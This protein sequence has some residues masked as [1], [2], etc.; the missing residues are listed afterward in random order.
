MRFGY[1]FL[2]CLALATH[3]GTG[4]RLHT[5]KTTDGIH[6]AAHSVKGVG[7]ILVY[8]YAKVAS[9]SLTTGLRTAGYGSVKFYPGPGQHGW[10]Q[11]MPVPA[12]YAS[13]SKTHE[14]FIAKDY[15]SRLSGFE[16]CLVITAAR[17]PFEHSVSYSFQHLKGNLGGMSNK[18]V[19]DRFHSEFLPK[20]Q[21]ED[22]KSGSQTSRRISALTSSIAVLTL[23][24]K[25]MVIG[26]HLDPDVQ[27]CSCASKTSALGTA[28]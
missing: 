14:R 2:L 7:R 28:Y 19:M 11:A 8:Q 4:L 25:A 27:F 16:Q 26:P 1:L 15:L 3:A 23:L 10:N 18:D 20:R 13:I 5:V 12:S 9:T 17:T 24:R 21:R 22:A 6:N